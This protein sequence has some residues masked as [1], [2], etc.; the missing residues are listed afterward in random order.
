MTD[1]EKQI[2]EFTTNIR[3]LIQEYRNQK[4]QIEK[5]KKEVELL[6]GKCERQE[7]MYKA[8]EKD[9]DSLKMARML[10][11]G[12]SDLETARQSI[13]K[14]IRDVNKCITL[15]NNVEQ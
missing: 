15:V 14:L 11:V 13:N 5:M 4:K 6:Q 9:Y 1:K 12:T 7:V 10:E 8:L 2:T 3:L